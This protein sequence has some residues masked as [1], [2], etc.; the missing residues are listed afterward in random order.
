[1]KLRM[2]TFLKY[3][4][5]VTALLAICFGYLIANGTGYVYLDIGADTYCSYWPQ[6]AFYQDILKN[7]DG[8][9][10]F[11]IGLGGNILYS[12]GMF[13]DPFN[14]IL[15]QF[16]KELLHLGILITALAKYYVLSVLAYWYLK[17]LKFDDKIIVV[18][19]LCYTF[20]GYFVGWGQHYWFATAF[21]LLTCCLCTFEYWM[22]NKKAIFFVIT[23]TSTLLFSLYFSY[24]ILLFLGIY[25]IFRYF[26]ICKATIKSFVHYLFRLLSYVMCAFGLSAVITI[27]SA[28]VLLQSAR[29]TGDKTLALKFDSIEYYISCIY[30]FFS[31][32]SL[33]INDFYATSNFFPTN[34]YEFPFLYVGIIGVILF[35]IIIRKN[36]I[37]KVGKVVF[38]TIICSLVFITISGPVFNG[39][40]TI[41]MRWTMVLVPVFTIAICKALQVFI[42]KPFEMKWSIICGIAFAI[43]VPLFSLFEGEKVWGRALSVEAINQLYIILTIVLLYSLLFIIISFK[44]T[45]SDKNYVFL[46]LI[47]II[48]LGTNM[49]VSV[50]ERSTV[51]KDIAPYHDHTIDAIAYLEEQDVGFYRVA[52]S[53]G[54]IDLSDPLIQN[55]NGEK[56]YVSSYSDY[57]SNFL[58]IYSLRYPQSNYFYGFDDKQ[59]LRNL[60][61]SKYYISRDMISKA[62]YSLKE[63]VEELYIYENTNA[64]PIAFYSNQAFSQSD[65]SNLPTDMREYVLYKGFVTDSLELCEKYQWKNT[66]D[67]LYL[68]EKVKYIPIVDKIQLTGIHLETPNKNAI[69][70]NFIFSDVAKKQMTTFQDSLVV[71]TDKSEIRIPVYFNKLESGYTNIE[72]D[73]L[74]VKEIE[75]AFDTGIIETV[76]VYEK[77]DQMI[78]E[79]CTDIKSNAFNIFN[80]SESEISGTVSLAESSMLISSIPY[81]SGWRVYVDGVKVDTHVVNINYL[82][83]EIPSGKHEVIFKYIPQGMQ[84]GIL[85]TFSTISVLFLLFKNSIKRGQ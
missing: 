64:I 24:M 21:I 1:M 51:G 62:G 11:K 25:V 8:F 14:L 73:I 2:Q 80:F 12:T 58:D 44:K 34:F 36:T 67:S 65:F 28:I 35:P 52:K 69:V 74:G 47:L 31:N 27:P 29:V 55:Y 48:D 41:T 83:V 70:L 84:I 77:N 63:Q 54:A 30:R 72:V 46:V 68:D 39:F 59:F 82:G 32:Y 61:G 9:W 42:E 85:C 60:A 75:W 49:F 43:F 10:S 20:N 66:V 6:Y 15:F 37:G 53:Y 79:L 71:K 38:V 40:S 50:D 33:G 57:F 18:G 19:A 5:G 22:I 76:L 17:M 23:V 3:E 45:F 4:L 7:F 56:Q 16:P 78:K 26:A 13:F 81:D